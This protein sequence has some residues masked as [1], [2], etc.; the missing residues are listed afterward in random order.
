LS[1]FEKISNYTIEYENFLKIVQE[2]DGYLLGL[3]NNNLLLFMD[4]IDKSLQE[5]YRVAATKNREKDFD[6]LFRNILAPKIFDRTTG[7]YFTKNLATE[8]SLRNVGLN[9]K[10][11]DYLHIVFSKKGFASTTEIDGPDALDTEVKPQGFSASLIRYNLGDSPGEYSPEKYG[12]DRC[13]PYINNTKITRKN[14]TNTEGKDITDSNGNPVTEITDLSKPDNEA[15]DYLNDINNLDFPDRFSKPNLT[16]YVVRDHGIGVLA[17][18]K[19]H[20]PIFFGA[21]PPIEMS[22]CTPYIDVKI[23]STDLGNS[24]VQPIDLVSFMRFTRNENGEFVSE[25]GIGLMGAADEAIKNSQNS[26]TTN[27]SYMDIFNSPQTLSNANINKLN[28][29]STSNNLVNSI[30]NQDHS[31]YEPIMPF[32]TL[33]SFNVSI[34]SAGTG[35]FASKSGNLKIVLHDRSRLKDIAPLVATDRFATTKIQIEFGW[36]H[37]DGGINSDN[38]IGQYLDSLKDIH[39]YQVLGSDYSFSG[40]NSVDIG[41]KLVA[42]GYRE[43]SNVHCGAGPYVPL[44]TLSDIITQAASQASQNISDDVGVFESKGV[45]EAVPEVRQNI[46]V[47]SRSARQLTSVIT[48]DQWG[49]IAS[50]LKNKNE[51]LNYITEFLRYQSEQDSEILTSQLQSPIS[52]FNPSQDEYFSALQSAVDVDQNKENLINSVFGKLLGLQA[53][54]NDPFVYSFHKSSKDFKGIDQ[55]TKT[56]PQRLIDLKNL[57]LDSKEGS[58]VTLGKLLLNYIGLPMASSCLYDEVQMVFYPFNHQ[59]GGARKHTTASLPINLSIIEKHLIDRMNKNSNLSV[60]GFFNLIEREILSDRNLPVYGFSELQSFKT[61]NELKD[62][63]TE[64]EKLFHGLMLL[65][66]MPEGVDASDTELNQYYATTNQNGSIT[67]SLVQGALDRE[68]RQ[69]ALES[70]S[71]PDNIKKKLRKLYDDYVS[72]TATQVRSEISEKCKQM[73]EDDGLGDDGILSEAKFVKPNV[74]LLFETNPA[75]ADQRD[76]SLGLVQAAQ[77]ALGIASKSDGLSDKSILRIHVYDE[78]A[79]ASP[80]ELTLINS[81]VSGTGGKRIL[82]S[83]PDFPSKKIIDKMTFY[84]AK[85]FVKRSYPTIIYG[86]A[87]STIKSLSVSANTSGE[88]ANVLMVESYGDFKNPQ[89]GNNHDTLFEEVTVF[90]NSVDCTIMGMPMITRGTSLFID[91]GT[92]TSLDSIYTVKSVNHTIASG[93]F[94]TRLE[95]VPSNMG[96]VSSFRDKIGDIQTKTGVS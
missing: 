85:E 43:A 45:K 21:I 50:K 77:I 17:R 66:E 4:D 75:I 53:D 78:E 72:Y 39:L 27:I 41:I 68:E 82:G 14:K 46:K 90:P 47:N 32:M 92:N 94:S 36:N 60:K 40:G 62:N 9:N 2:F 73:Y 80:A 3:T 63:K 48:W 44:N 7:T 1:K 59:A 10:I 13:L 54:N 26:E 15:V 93:E 96:A 49:T 19:N 83:S 52:Q 42:H 76:E 65:D 51:L 37:P 35:L 24:K 89:D 11:D 34:T 55:S 67:S 31:V 6:Y 20:L 25:D 61:L 38:I 5:A 58:F 22:R 33:K 71:L 16:G 30:I 12:I 81:L 23:I 56:G 69:T 29:G 64:D 18:Q 70:L 88:L 95:L 57:S 87:A 91:F 8:S 74:T 86:S 28:I 79:I 84:D